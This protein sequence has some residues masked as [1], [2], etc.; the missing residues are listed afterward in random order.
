MINDSN[1]FEKLQ[2]SNY[3]I[4]IAKIG[5]LNCSQPE[6]KQFVRPNFR[7]S[8]IRSDKLS[9]EAFGTSNSDTTSISTQFQCV[10]P[11]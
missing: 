7:C 5:F 6:Y 8:N 10:Y 4:I 2:N 11:L 3:G 1:R 9:G